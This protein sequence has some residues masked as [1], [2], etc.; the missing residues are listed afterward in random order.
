VVGNYT[1]ATDT[2][3]FLWKKSFEILR[4]GPLFRIELT[5][6]E[7]TRETWPVGSTQ[8]VGG[9]AEKYFEIEKKL[10]EERYSINWFGAKDGFEGRMRTDCSPVLVAY[11]F[12]PVP[13]DEMLAGKTAKLSS[14]RPVNLN[15]VEVVEVT[16]E[17]K[18]VDGTNADERY[19][20]QRGSWALIDASATY[21]DLSGRVRLT[22]RKAVS[23][24]GNDP[25][26]VKTVD[27][28]YEL[29]TDRAG[30]K[31][32]R[33]AFEVTTVQFGPIPADRFSLASFGLEEP[34]LPTTGRRVFW[35]LVM[36]AGLLLTMGV[37]F[38]AAAR[39]RRKIR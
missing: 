2:G 9:S 27:E 28:W 29:P 12:G 17:S 35:T 16:T 38:A 10:G 7:S 37:W 33:R 20:F 3:K 11:S 30:E 23:Y 13:L 1:R 8:A 6:L 15:G 21:K 36:S 26:I 39:R 25:P 24:D 32:G 19:L 18:Q 4:D 34:A 31:R 14:V 22:G 5:A